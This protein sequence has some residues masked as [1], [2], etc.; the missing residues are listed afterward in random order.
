[1]QSKA[2]SEQK[3]LA[4]T[5]GS[6]ELM[7]EGHRVHAMQRVERKTSDSGIKSSWMQMPRGSIA[8]LRATPACFLQSLLAP[9]THLT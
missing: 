2:R 3:R 6:D 4:A 8:R 1:M 9:G 7:E 5:A